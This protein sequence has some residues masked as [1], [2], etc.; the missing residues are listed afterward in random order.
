MR[1]LL[2]RNLQVALCH[3]FRIE[4]ESIDE[5]P[6]AEPDNGKRNGKFLLVFGSGQAHE[7]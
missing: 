3:G 1:N 5:Q 6:V 4:T 2:P 7:S